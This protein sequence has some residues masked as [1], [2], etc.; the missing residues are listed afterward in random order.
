MIDDENII[1]VDVTADW[2]ATCQ[3]NKINVLNKSIIKNEF[4]KLN[5]IK[6]RA[7]WTKPNDKIEKYLQSHNKFGIPMNI[8]YSKNNKNGIILSEILIL[9][10]L[11]ETLRNQK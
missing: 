2:C 4:K 10:N 8:I 5:I 7:D 9:N 1:F 3:F 11:L 6:V